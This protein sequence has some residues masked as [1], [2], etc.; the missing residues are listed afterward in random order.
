M[1]L[2]CGYCVKTVRRRR[3]LYF[4]HYEHR[5]GRRQQGEEYVGPVTDSG[6]RDRVARKGAAHTE[7]AGIEMG[8]VV[9]LTRAEMGTGG[10]SSPV[11]RYRLPA[12]TGR[13]RAPPP[14]P[15]PPRG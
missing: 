4:W 6:A 12:I 11:A 7:R 8:R 13:G 3:Y 15:A 14:R 2:G 10:G 1:M 5:G 9:A